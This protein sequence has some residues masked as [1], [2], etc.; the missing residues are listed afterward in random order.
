[1]TRRARL[2]TVRRVCPGPWSFESGVAA[3]HLTAAVS[4]PTFFAIVLLCAVAVPIASC[5]GSSSPP[6]QVASD[7]P[8]AGQ[9]GL[10]ARVGPAG[11]TFSGGGLSVVVPAGAVDHEIELAIVPTT[12]PVPPGYRAASVLYRAT[13]EGQAFARPL[14]VTLPF[15]GSSPAAVYWSRASGGYDSLGGTIAGSLITAAVPHFSTGFVG[16]EASDA[17]VPTDS[18]AIDSG[19]ID[20]GPIDSGALDSG[21]IDSG[22]LDSG[23]ID[24][25]AVDAGVDVPTADIGGAE[26]ME[27]CPAVE[28]MSSVT[29]TEPCGF[30]GLECEFYDN[31]HPQ[32]YCR[33]SWICGEYTPGSYRWS[34]VFNSCGGD[35]Q[36]CLSETEMRAGAACTTGGLGRGWCE[37]PTGTC[38]CRSGHYVCDDPTATAGCPAHLPNLGSPCPAEA[39]AC[40][41]GPNPSAVYARRVCRRGLWRRS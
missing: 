32:L 1:M 27:S 38:V 6:Q 31:A 21:P 7:V 30:P 14:V 35:S 20:S 17:G 4:H 22:T 9:S 13:P 37:I 18:G 33:H 28:P 41:F 10:H 15:S 34:G 39:L 23:P 16:V 26:V 5:D 11:G 40:D 29:P 8:D 12:L 3:A 19:A 36:T 24:T 2:A 25:G